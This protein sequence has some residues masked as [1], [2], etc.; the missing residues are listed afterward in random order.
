MAFQISVTYL[1]PSDEASKEILETAY[2][3][4]AQF[5]GTS[6]RFEQGISRKKELVPAITAVLEA[7]PKE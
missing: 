3:D 4:R 7:Y 2:G 5:D 6:F 1:V